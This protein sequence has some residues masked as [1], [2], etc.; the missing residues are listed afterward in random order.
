MN[1][2]VAAVL[3]L[4][5]STLCLADWKF[6]TQINTG[7]EAPPQ[8]QIT[9][10]KGQRVRYEVPNREFLLIYQCDQDRLLKIN[11]ADK[12]YFASSLNGIR[13]AEARSAEAQHSCCGI[14]RVHQ[15]VTETTEHKQMFGL[16]AQRIVMQVQLRPGANAC[17]RDANLERELDGWYT[18][19]VT[20]PDCVDPEHM[21][22]ANGP[23]AAAP[24]YPERDRHIIDGKGIDPKLFALNV[25]TRDL[26]TGS[27]PVMFTRDVVSLSSDPL[28]D[29]LFEVPQGFTERPPEPMKV[30]AT[31]C[32]G[33]TTSGSVLPDGTT[34]YRPSSGIVMP[35]PIY[36]PE[37]QY[38]DA[39]RKAKVSGTVVLSFTVTSEGS[40]RDARVERS[41]RPDLDEQALATVS[42]WR[43]QP[44]IKDGTPVPVRLNVEVSFNLR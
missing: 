40:V 23:K 15:Q 8:I 30:P 20:F 37:P 28:P 22:F 9:Y 43:F 33:T 32:A 39:A 4:H 25:V 7:P 19:Q 5:A 34:P 38:T 31:N 42:T 3:L 18:D 35:K 12:S 21:G 41:L 10:V 14:I 6:E 2:V 17:A 26:R 24:G 1:K 44:G 29:D 11:S 27:M 36:H 13:Q 16:D